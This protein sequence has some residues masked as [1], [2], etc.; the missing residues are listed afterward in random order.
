MSATRF[1]RRRL[2]AAFGW[3]G[4]TLPYFGR[5]AF[6]R[7]AGSRAPNR[8]L[9]VTSKTFAQVREKI[10][11]AGMEALRNGGHALDAAEK[12]VNVS[13][14]DPLDT[15]VGYGGDP[16][17][18]GFLQLDASIMSG[19]D[20]CAS[21]AVAALEN[22][23]RPTSVA[24]LVM[25][26]TDHS[27]LVGK[28]ALTFARLH[29]FKEEDLLT[30]QARDHWREWKENLNPRDY[31]FA[32]KDRPG[33]AP[34]P[35]TP[36]QLDELRRRLEDLDSITLLV[37]DGNGD[38]AGATSTVGH[39]FKIVGR[40]GDSPIVGAGLYVD[41]AVGAAGATGHGD[42]IVR[43]CASFHVVEKM[44]DGMSPQQ[45]CEF[46]CQRTIDRHGGRPM[47][48]F[49]LVALNTQG[50]YGCC[51]VRGRIGEKTRAVL[52]QGFFVHD[53]RGPRIEEGRGLMPPLTDEELAALPW[54]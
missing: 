34:A 52:G 32:P 45:A 26:R 19:R 44:R 36:R 20:G 5:A 40:V 43:H 31:Y 8:P 25:E 7:Q 11:T 24:R 18:E 49:K 10:T 46:V 29:G 23:K 1:T 6:A 47:F 54:R 30:D 28:G 38:V 14:T 27:L 17:E 16:N 37:L 4:V 51:S 2:F 13:E 12:A 53:A 21:G 39:H 15:T 9:I 3:A 41:N 48:N 35:R 42:E 33:A 22:I 50:D